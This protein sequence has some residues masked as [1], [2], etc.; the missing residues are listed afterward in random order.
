MAS[1][2]IK[3]FFNGRYFEIPKYQR[4]YAWEKP[5]IRDLFEDIQEAI[6]VDASHYIGTLVLSRSEKKDVYYVVDG[7]Q[8]I[9]TLSMII[10]GLVKL[11]DKEDAIYYNRFYIK[12]GEKHRLVP[13]GRENIFYKELM[14]NGVNGQ[15][16]SNRSQRLLIEAHE[17]ISE[18]LKQVVQFI[19]PITYLNHIEDL[20]IMEFV[21]DSP[22]N[23]IRIFQ[24]VNDRGKPLTNM[25]KAKSLL[26]Y[27][28]NR[29]LDGQ[30]DNK[31]NDCF[32]NIF[33]RYD[34][35]KHLGVEN[36]IDLISGRYGDFNEDNI[37]RYHFITFSEEDYDPSA[38]YVL[39][40]LKRALKELRKHSE[41]KNKIRDFITS[42]TNSLFTFF[43][44]LHDL[45]RS[46]SKNERYYKVFSIL[47]LSATLYPIATVL[48]RQGRLETN[49]VRPD[50]T[51]LDL[52]EI[53]DVRVY[54]VRGTD[55]KADIAKI[56]Y[57]LNNDNLKDSDA[58]GWLLW[59]NERWMGAEEFRN[60]MMGAVYRRSKA[61]LPHVLLDYSENLSNRV[62]TL[63]ELK[64]LVKKKA[65]SLEHIL[66]QKPKFT[67]KTHGFKST[68]EYLE[69]EHTLGNLTL[70]E[71][72]L[73]SSI[74]NK[75]VFDKIPT[76]DKSTFQVT[77]N[78]ATNVS[79]TN[80]FK[81]E[82][83][84]HRTG[85]VV[86]YLEKKWWCK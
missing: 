83:I 51:F 32:G 82:D 62:L 70:L 23:A 14:E 20:Q 19:D 21:E 73:N 42:Y 77:K 9:T 8:R 4:G 59:F 37:M 84:Q 36:D 27:F 2:R 85:E 11:M 60:N 25:E 50:T 33:E 48:N 12:H 24:T 7:Q 74:K 10:N 13:L 72:S 71:K 76:Y 29:Y 22:G 57:S 40:Y 41:F 79:H 66:S 68:E 35:I 1:I 53:I 78:L 49:L 75:N 55:P 69:Y 6:E 81:K 43:E 54:K 3:E 17:E 56:A 30:L 58:E 44:A 34:E 15:A 39:G 64:D 80:Q 65:L 46:A 16:P 18:R 61:V 28:S 86:A 67:L 5:N 45:L 47:G 38:S 26:V 63:D 31:I 52:L